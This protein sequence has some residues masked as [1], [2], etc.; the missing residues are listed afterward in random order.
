MNNKTF[1]LELAVRDEEG[2]LIH[3]TNVTNFRLKEMGLCFFDDMLK[4]RKEILF[5]I[6]RTTHYKD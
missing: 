2:K 4:E 1:T 6:L 5:D 3:L